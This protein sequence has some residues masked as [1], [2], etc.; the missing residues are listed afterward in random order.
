MNGKNEVEQDAGPQSAN[1]SESGEAGAEPLPKQELGLF[2]SGDQPSDQGKPSAQVFTQSDVDR[3]VRERLEREKQ[4]REKAA[5]KAKEEA[6]ADAMKKYQDWQALAQANEKKAGELEA[7]LGELEP[8]NDQVTRY[9]GALDKYLEAEKRDLPKHVLVLLEKLDPVEQIE[10]LSEN[11]EALGAK[12]A[13]A[14]AAAGVPASPNPRQRTMS[15]E[16]K[17]AARRGQAALYTNF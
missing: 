16:D 10:Y 8:L 2:R 3:I 6:E 14:G 1:L 11:R 13:S 9:K 7:R 17:E 12:P 15:E 5:A 4:A